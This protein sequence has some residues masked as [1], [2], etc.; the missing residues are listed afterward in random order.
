MALKAYSESQV[1]AAA[2]SDGN[3]ARKERQR[4]PGPAVLGMEESWIRYALSRLHSEPSSIVAHGRDEGWDY[5]AGSSGSRAAG[6]RCGWDCDF[7]LRS[8]RKS[9][10]S[11]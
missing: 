1:R 5:A 11:E 3:V 9:S 4:I 7:G 10:K 2:G 8:P 6:T